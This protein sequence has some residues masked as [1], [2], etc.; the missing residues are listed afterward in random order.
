MNRIPGASVR[1]GMRRI[2][3]LTLVLAIMALLVSCS[4]AEPDS[5]DATTGD[6]G[7][8]TSAPAGSDSGTAITIA[9]FAF[10]GASTVSVGDT[11]TVTNDDSVGH[12]WTAEGGEFDSGTIDP[13]ASFDF[14]FETEGVFEYV[15]SI[16]PQMSGS[17]TVEA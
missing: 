12:T 11:V 4:D 16:H 10:S 14:T 5:P 3:L 1:N 9:D 17:I 15:C 2:Q 8:T 7:S 6:D 13:G